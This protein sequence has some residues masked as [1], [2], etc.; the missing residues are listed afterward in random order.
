MLI[1]VW[2]KSFLL[3]ALAAV[4]VAGSAVI[5][6]TPSNFEKVVL[7]SGK[8]TLV[9]FFAPWCGHCKQLAPVWEDLASTFEHVKEKVQIA[10]VDADAER[11]LGKKYGIQGF[12]TLKWFNGKSKDP[13]DYSGGRDLDSLSSYITKKIGVK[14]KRKLEMPSNVEMLTDTTF[15]KAIG[16]DKNVLVA[17]TAPW[18]GRKYSAWKGAFS[19]PASP[20]NAEN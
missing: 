15:P 11:E 19:Q 4:T 9:E 3:T 12:P 13:E 14:A 7:K 10:K 18:C 16:G 2:T 6:L 20:A 17:F 1:M 8:P 5:D